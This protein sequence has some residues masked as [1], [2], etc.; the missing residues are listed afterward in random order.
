M[1]SDEFNLSNLLD[2]A[3]AKEEEYRDKLLFWKQRRQEL[4][5][6]IPSQ[7]NIWSEI[8]AI[9]EEAWNNVTGNRY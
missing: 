7:N 3:I 2:E 1:T 8:L 6:Q 4:Q 5:S 9:V